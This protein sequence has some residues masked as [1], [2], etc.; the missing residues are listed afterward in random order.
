MAGSI[1]RSSEGRRRSLS[2]ERS[3]SA[4]QRSTLIQY[5]IK[6]ARECDAKRRDAMQGSCKT[7]SHGILL[8]GRFVLEVGVPCVRNV[9]L[10]FRD[11]R[12]RRQRRCRNP[13]RFRNGM[14]HR[15]GHH[16][17]L[18][19]LRSDDCSRRLGKRT[20]SARGSAPIHKASKEQRTY[21]GVAIA[22]DRAPCFAGRLTR[23]RRTDAAAATAQ[24]SERICR[25]DRGHT[26]RS[27][28]GATGAGA[29]TIRSRTV[30][31]GACDRSPR[32]ACDATVIADHRRLDGDAEARFAD[33]VTERGAN[34]RELALQ[35]GNRRVE[36]DEHVFISLPVETTTSVRCPFGMK[37]PRAHAPPK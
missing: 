7:K 9:L 4:D 27:L 32:A 31:V 14:V 15:N 34:G 5:A 8:C 26:P 28:R 21:L 6:A 37:V 30:A 16:S 20:H 1:R 3:C 35:V 24:R 29:A 12:R 18:F 17:F 23:L 19:A 13:C 25:L 36:R 11:G 2:L 33:D 10:V 22:D